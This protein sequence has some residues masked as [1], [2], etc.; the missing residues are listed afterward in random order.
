MVIEATPS[1]DGSYVIGQ[2][3][4]IVGKGN[5][6][7]EVF[8]NMVFN[9]DYIINFRPR[10]YIFVDPLVSNLSREVASD[11]PPRNGTIPNDRTVN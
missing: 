6:S 1:K 2:G 7:A 9:I 11:N 8:L 4:D 3:S 5:D 10:I